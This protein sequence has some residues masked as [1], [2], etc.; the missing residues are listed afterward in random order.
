MAGVEV[1]G[2][3]SS[4]VLHSRSRTNCEN[5]DE[6]VR[7]TSTTACD[8]STQ[9]KQSMPGI[10]AAPHHTAD[11]RGFKYYILASSSS[12]LSSSSGFLVFQL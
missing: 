6:D 4:T 2:N 5:V 3:Q 7:Q 9:L 1:T 10:S 8:V 11:H 12:S